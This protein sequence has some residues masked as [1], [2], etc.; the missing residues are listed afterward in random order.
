MN[1]RDLVRFRSVD[2]V[3]QARRTTLKPQ[4]RF[5]IQ[6]QESISATDEVSRTAGAG[7]YL[8]ADWSTHGC[9]MNVEMGRNGKVGLGK[10]RAP[11]RELRV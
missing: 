4:D 7:W 10:R 2:P 6:R 9:G 11:E 5:A 8:S 1:G 3:I